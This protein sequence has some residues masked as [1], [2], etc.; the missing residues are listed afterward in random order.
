[1]KT[2]S[3]PASAN[4]TTDRPPAD[5]GMTTL[6]L[7]LHPGWKPFVRPAPATRAWMDDTAESFAYRC[8]PLN[9]A[10][11]HGWEFLTACGFSAEWNGGRAT[12]DITITPDRA[13]GPN[14]PVS[15]FGY[16]VLTFH[17]Q[18]LIRTPPG[19][20]IYVTGSP[21]DVRDG[22]APL[23]GVIE[24]DWS[25]YSFT[26]NWKFTRP[27]SIRFEAGEPF[28]FFFP[29]ERG[30]LRRFEPRVA[31][32]AEEPEVADQFQRWSRS[33]DAFRVEIEERIRKE[34]VPPTEKWQKRYYRGVDMD[35]RTVVADHEARLRLPVF[36]GLQTE[37]DGATANGGASAMASVQTSRRSISTDIVPEHQTL[38]GHDLFMGGTEDT[39][40]AMLVAAG[41]T[42]EMARRTVAETRR[43]PLADLGCDIGRRLRRREW[44]MRADVA[45]KRRHGRLSGIDRHPQISRE[46]FLRDYLGLNL[47]VALPGVAATWPAVRHWTPASLASVI[48]DRE[49][50]VVSGPKPFGAAGQP[51]GENAQPM[52]FPAF[53]RDA[54]DFRRTDRL[55]L[56]SE[57]GAINRV[58]LAPLHAGMTPLPA[59]LEPNATA[60][61]AGLFMEASGSF[62][63]LHYDLDDRLVVQVV[64]RRIVKLVPPAE[65]WRL[66]DQSGRW[67]DVP[68]IDDALTD[69]ERK[70]A[71]EGLIHFDILVGPGDALFIPVGWWQQSRTL[72]FTVSTAFVCSGGTTDHGMPAY[73]SE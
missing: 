18:A 60:A 69:P 40:V 49:V 4:T 68:D 16:G 15:I 62:T 27:G 71:L 67:S 41:L 24:A 42:D 46:S 8:L 45:R 64:G 20:N 21:N 65:V 2:P 59:V 5:D 54:M 52:T 23:S 37:V 10:N 56:S 57:M 38:I 58:A 26:M 70:S 55:V 6:L 30:G 9:I 50:A 39:L 17:V 12:T 13:D 48:G 72:D 47:P 22:I 28:L 61:S 63:A 34:F 43:A 7:V 11:S 29:V 31:S 35:D 32:F 51:S 25:P 19:W 53:L 36:P 73:P 1:M 33:R 14:L 3:Q 44:I 66:G